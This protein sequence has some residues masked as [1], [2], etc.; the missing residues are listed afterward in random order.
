MSRSQ[1]LLQKIRWEMKQ[2]REK[3]NS[4][5]QRLYE[6]EMGILKFCIG[7]ELFQHAWKSE[8][9]DVLC[10]NLF[11]HVKNTLGK[12]NFVSQIEVLEPE[13][14]TAITCVEKNK[15]RSKKLRLLRLYLEKLRNGDFSPPEAY[16]PK[17]LLEEC[18]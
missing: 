10:Q 2:N 12:S 17:Q 1:K 15:I 16:K 18:L 11:A 13:I 14:D 5:K 9:L 3:I 8:E 6:L 4:E 7:I